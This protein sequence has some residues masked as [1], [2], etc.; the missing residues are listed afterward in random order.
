MILCLV[1]IKHLVFRTGSASVCQHFRKGPRTCSNVRMGFHI[2]RQAG[3]LLE[4]HSVPDQ[5][6]PWA[7]EHAYIRR[8]LLHAAKQ[9]STCQGAGESQ[10]D[11]EGFNYKT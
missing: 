10:L 8:Q 9:T 4:I 3:Q 2:N 6:K 1:L 11:D 7:G 5:L